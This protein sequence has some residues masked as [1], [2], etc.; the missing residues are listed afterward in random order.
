MGS[1]RQLKPQL[2]HLKK[3]QML[4]Y[5]PSCSISCHLSF[6]LY[7]DGLFKD[8]YY[9]VCHILINLKQGV[10]QH[11]YSLRGVRC[12]VF[13]YIAGTLPSNHIGFTIT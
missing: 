11:W 8:T 7:D 2:L 6:Q 12:V 10:K 5:V 1:V 9:F 13:S 3:P 4:T